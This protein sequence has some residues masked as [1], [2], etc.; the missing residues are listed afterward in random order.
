MKEIFKCIFC[1]TYY[2]SK[3]AF[4]F[5]KILLICSAYFIK[6][7]VKN[8]YI[9]MRAKLYTEFYELTKSIIKLIDNNSA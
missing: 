9:I 2:F 5:S 8:I 4:S 7:K 1:E 6:T 3:I